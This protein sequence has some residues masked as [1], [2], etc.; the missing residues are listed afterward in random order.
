MKRGINAEVSQSTGLIFPAVRVTRRIERPMVSIVVPTRN[1]LDLLR[2]C[3]ETIAPAAGRGPTEIIVVDNDT[4]DPETLEF[5]AAI[6]GDLATVVRAPGSFNFARL[7]NMALSYARGEFLCLLN[8][9]SRRPMSCG[10]TNGEPA[11]RTR[12]RSGRRTP[13][14]AEWHC[15]ARRR[16]SWLGALRLPM[17][18]KIA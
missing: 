18:S 10:S 12:C 3:L 11:R 9:E 1:R 14:L 8:N 4:S 13:V 5:L 7:N 15:S 6:D 16:C 17:R 2:R